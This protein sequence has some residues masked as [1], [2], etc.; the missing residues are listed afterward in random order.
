MNSIKKRPSGYKSAT[1]SIA[2]LALPLIMFIVATP[3]AIASFGEGGFGLLLFLLSLQA[4][5]LSIDFGLTA[6]GVVLIAKHITTGDTTAASRVLSEIVVLFFIIGAAVLLSIYLITG[7]LDEGMIFGHDAAYVNELIR[8]L[9][10]GVFVGMLA[11]ALSLFLRALE[12]I[13]YMVL[14]Q[15]VYSAGLWVGVLLV[16]IYGGGLKEVLWFGLGLYGIQLALYLVWLMRSTAYS[17]QPILTANWHLKGV[18]GYSGFAFVAQLSSMVTYH[19][20]RILVGMLSG[21]S[22]VTY[23]AVPANI[24]SRLLNVG[25]LFNSFVFP[26]AITLHAVDDYDGLRELYLKASRYTFLLLVPVLVPLVIFAPE[27]LQLWLGEAFAENAQMTARILLMAFFIAATSITPSQIY[28]GMGNSRIGAIY[29][30]AGSAINVALCIIL[31]PMFGALGAAIASLV[32]MLQALLYR[33]S[34]EIELE[35]DRRRQGALHLMIAAV[36]LVQ[37]LICLLA[38]RFMLFADIYSALFT[39]MAVW[40]LFYAVWL[41]LPAR[42]SSKERMLCKKVM[43][44]VGL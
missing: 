16:A 35:I 25:A 23:Y 18:M 36:A 19:I 27:L 9:A 33:R 4:L 10:L 2:G 38:Q 42:F 1:V 20:D 13:P 30:L 15:N 34:L 12:Q 11:N 28:N 21:I 44:K 29:S 41:M 6:G 5:A 43:V 32:A 17:F 22:Q 7:M 8:V 31:I 39:L 26:R 14:V 24:V 37:G 40:L 3:F